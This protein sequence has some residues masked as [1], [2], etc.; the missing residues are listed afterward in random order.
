[1]KVV[2][3]Y[4]V[5]TLLLDPAYMPFGVATARAAFYSLLKAKGAGLDANG[6]PYKWDRYISRKISV[7][8][9]QPFLRSGSNSAYVDNIWVIPT[10][11]VANEDFFFKRKRLRKERSENNDGNVALPP[12]KEVYDYY[13]GTCCFCFRKIKLSEASREHIHS[14]AFGGKNHDDNIALACKPCNSRA[15]HAMPK[16][17]VHGNPVEAKMKI[18][19]AHYVL[20]PNVKARPEWAPYLFQAVSV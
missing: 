9:E 15:G 6:V 17:D 16:M 20:P 13:K 2:D 7:I 4:E 18:R 11:F 1:M 8:P 19:P 14:K 5:T 10:V 3:P 12:L